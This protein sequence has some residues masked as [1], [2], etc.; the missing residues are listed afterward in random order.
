MLDYYLFNYLKN[1]TSLNKD[2]LDTLKFEID[3]NIYHYGDQFK[4]PRESQKFRKLNLMNVLK[5]LYITLGLFFSQKYDIDKKNIVSGAYFT[6]R[7]E[8]QKLGFNVYS[9]VWA[10][11]KF[12]ICADLN[13]YHETQKLEN[14][15]NKDSLN[16]ILKPLFLRRIE[17]FREYL[18][19]YYLKKNISALIAP[20]DI[21][22]FWMLS[23][24]IFK[25]IKRPSFV[26]THGFPHRHNAIDD[27]RADYL[28]V[29]G[30]KIKDCY[31]K[32]GV[33]PNKIFVSGHPL[34]KTFKIQEI[35]FS[36]ENILVI[37]KGMAG[38]QESSDLLILSD[39]G[40][41]ISYLYS[42]QNVLQKFGIRSV[43]FRPHPSENGKWYLKHLDNNFFKLDAENLVK[44]LNMSSLVIGPTSTVFLEAFF[45]GVNYVI[46]E[47][48][49]NGFDLLNFKL[50]PPFDSSDSR[51]PTANSEKELTNL[52]KDRTKV[53]FSFIHDYIK[54]PFDLSFM[55]KLL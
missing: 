35:K 7:E 25:K 42:V 50:V 10:K 33:N 53:D 14:I 6:Y 21:P 44:S 11:K 28:V 41:S 23:I 52:L 47:P 9:T 49:S 2:I 18:E 15:F 5:D 8:L 27:N 17:L 4:N 29:L 45:Y 30:E 36:F 40:S 34:Y 24:Q 20:T 19:Q 48:S 12:P 39:R 13:I 37:T 43:R 26:F 22:F 32:A 51:V 16:E 31:V 55:K 1:N 38:A 46:Y 54:T 3:K